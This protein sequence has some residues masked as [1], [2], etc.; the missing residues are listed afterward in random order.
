MGVPIYRFEPS[1]PC[2]LSALADNKLWISDP[3][4]FN[5]PFDFVIKIENFISRSGFDVQNFK[6]A[7][8]I[9]FA[10]YN[11]DEGHRLY[12]Q[13]IVDL[14]LKW[15]REN[16]E[17]NRGPI[18]NTLQQY[19]KSFGVQCFSNHWN[20]PLNW[21]HYA[22]QHAGF[23]VEY[24][25]EQMTFAAKNC[26]KMSLHE[27][28]YTNELPELCL[29][30]VLFSPHQTLNRF[31][32]TKTIDWAYEGETRVVHFEAQGKSVDMP[33][34]LKIASLIAGLKVSNKLLDSLV[35]TAKALDVQVY[36]VVKSKRSQ[37]LVRE[38]IN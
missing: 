8:E 22:S 18:I 19:L 17:R 5:D 23:C 26:H 2:R 7:V 15:S 33:N 36:K 1:C 13:K 6:K 28:V 35:K 31:L 20:I 14:I 34:G 25:L 21:A 9:L 24:D 3:N 32:A 30:E 4:K 29:S 10:N 16:S 11:L 38:E 37:V 12:S 27:V